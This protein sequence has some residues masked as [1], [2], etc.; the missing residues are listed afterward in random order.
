MSQIDLLELVEAEAYHRER[1]QE[2][3]CDLP[4]CNT[5]SDAARYAAYN[6]VRGLF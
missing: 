4:G 3:R 6:E 1:V 2:A 5:I